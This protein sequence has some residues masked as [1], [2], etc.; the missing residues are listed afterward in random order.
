[1]IKSTKTNL[2]VDWG[3]KVYL[4]PLL[5]FGLLLRGCDRL[6]LK[7][8]IYKGTHNKKNWYY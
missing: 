6:V 4:F 7:Y 3:A 1:M 2:L 8:K 5:F